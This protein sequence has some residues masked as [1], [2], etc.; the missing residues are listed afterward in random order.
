M[1]IIIRL[2]IVCVF[3]AF[4][5]IGVKKSKV[6]HKNGLYIIFIALS[7]I[8]ITILSL[9][10][11]ENLFITFDSPESAYDYYSIGES[12]VELVVE[13]DNCEFVV[14]REN[15]SNTYLII[16]KSNNGWKIGTGLNTK[17][18]TQIIS[19]GIVIYVYR[20]K[21]TNDYFVT[22]LDTAGGEASISDE[23]G[24]KFL[25]SPKVNNSLEKVFV[26]YYAHIPYSEL[27]YSITVNGEKIV[28]KS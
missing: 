27:G 17:R 1:Y 7:L 11:F 25:S 9:I 5:V 23:Y 2:L 19:D 21:D 16:P 15:D 10:P 24:T 28:L 26:T 22:I 3:F 6:I 8:L 18:I 14:N 12:N 20:Y 4:S 13:G